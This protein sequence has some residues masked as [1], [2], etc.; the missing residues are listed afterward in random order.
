MD[1]AV[2]VCGIALI[3]VFAVISLKNL[4]DS[5][6]VLV[7][8]ASSV[9]FFG[10]F[11]G[12][13]YPF[14]SFVKTTMNDGGMSGYT[15]LLFKALGIAFLTG[16]SS[17]VCRDSGEAGIAQGVETVGRAEIL[18]LAVPLLEDLFGMAKEI[19]TW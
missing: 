1:T 13:L 9:V 8:L 3:C 17:S 15:G 14:V 5:C 10:L 19:L 6:A 11:C 16:I 18:L 2:K 4:K 12:M 7:R